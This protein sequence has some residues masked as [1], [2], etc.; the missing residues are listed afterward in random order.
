MKQALV[1][2]AALISALLTGCAGAPGD[3]ATGG[4][5]S[6]ATETTGALIEPK[7]EIATEVIDELSVGREK[8]TFIGYKG[9]TGDTDFVLRSETSKYQSSSAIDQL[10]T[11]YGRLTTLEIF[12]ALSHGAKQ[13][14]DAIVAAHRAE[15]ESFGRADLAVHQVQ[16]QAPAVEKL[17]ANACDGFIFGQFIPQDGG[18]SGGIWAFWRSPASS[19]VT[20]SMSDTWVCQRNNCNIV[21]WT[22]QVVGVC[23]ESTVTSRAALALTVGNWAW[24]GDEFPS[25]G[26]GVRW[27]KSR[28]G[29]QHLA[30][31][32]KSTS[33]GRQFVLRGNEIQWKCSPG[34]QCL[35][36][37]STSNDEIYP[38]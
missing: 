32:S 30:L 27:Y 3:Q 6:G 7:G 5:E 19:S 34:M 20:T 18:R 26:V 17:A 23:S 35:I 38:N 21:K 1:I 31:R 33:A 16:Y 4:Q 22:N 13:P 10:I 14:K 37:S 36:P 12:N 15:A 2:S 11:Q 24:F 29:F 8:V 28:T 9:D 25:N